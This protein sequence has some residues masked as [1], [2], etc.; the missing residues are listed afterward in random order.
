MMNVILTHEQ[1]D[2]DAIASMLGA[3]L[4]ND[5]AYPILPKRINRNVKAFLTLYG[6]DLPYIEAR[7]LPN[8]DIE[9]VI[10]VDTQS[11][12]SLKGMTENTHVHV[13]DHHPLREDIPID[14]N[15]TVSATGANTTLFVESMQEGNILLSSIQATLLILGIYE[16]TGSLT[17]SRTTARD[18]RSASFL[19]EQGANL[20]LASSFLNHPLSLTQQAI[21]TRIWENLEFLDLHGHTIVI[22]DTDASDTDEELSTIAHKIRET[23]DP[24]GLFILVTTKGGVQLIARSSNDDIDVSAIAGYFGGGGHE[25]AAAGLIKDQS[26]DDVKSVL[27]KILPE[28]IKPAMQVSQI[29]SRDPQLLP[30][31]MPVDEVSLRMQRFGYEGFPVVDKGKVVGLITR[32]AVDRALAHKL[33]LSASQLMEAGKYSVKPDDS[34]DTLQRLMTES[35]WGQIPVIEPNTGKI[36]GIVTRTDLINILPN[37][38]MRPSQRSLVER[39]EHALPIERTALLKKIAEIASQKQIAL[40]I[41]GGFVRDLLL[42][43]PSMDFDL[44]VEGDAI[45]LAHELARHYGGRVTSHTRF[46]TAKWTIKDIKKRIV[47]ELEKYL[48]QN[49]IETFKLSKDHL[50]N[51]LDLVSARTEFYTHP[52]ALPTIEQGSIKLDLHRRDFTIN[53]LA[54]R[55]DGRN[56]GGLYDYW[57]GYNDLKQ[58]VV[59]VLHSLSFVDDPTRILRAIR[60]EQRFNFK[61]DPRTQEFLIEA[62]PLLDRVSGDRIRHELDHIFTELSVVKMLKRLS[63]LDVLTG[64]HPVL[65]WD[66]WIEEKIRGLLN[67]QLIKEWEFQEYSIH[68][69]ILETI[70]TLF[71]IRSLQNDFLD[72]VKRLRLSASLV[73]NMEFARKLWVECDNLTGMSPSRFTKQLEE[74]PIRSLFSV[75]IACDDQ[76]LRNNLVTMITKW[77]NIKTY[78]SGDDLRNR[79][80]PPG[81]VYRRILDELRSAWLDGTIDTKDEEEILMNKLINKLALPDSLDDIKYQ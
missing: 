42:D 81:P 28:Y 80:I 35:G 27:L 9:R 26:L 53:T 31:D 56:Y 78:H 14:W 33:K 38:N 23:L 79:G 7:D 70:Y 1:A 16:D 29:M 3:Y 6:S 72:G 24:D 51:S 15:I 47:D 61:I 32:R 63:E 41:V 44:V 13:I 4:L 17:Y 2:F 60:F 69:V 46:G 62:I 37:R 67:Y 10:L 36:I 49:G 21:Y 65:C 75:S 39:L 43:R 20:S 19:L 8:L 71:F 58:G 50:P 18:L 54:L 45:H 66:H 74:I 55:L 57:G 68:Q 30:P 73:K 5:N 25:R 22:G 11:I 52:T 76:E 59:R 34:I 48:N 40:Y 77:R 64:I 12:I